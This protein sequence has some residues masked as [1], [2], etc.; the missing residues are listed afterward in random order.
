MRELM[1]PVEIGDE[2]A[3]TIA[4]GMREVSLADGEHPLELELI[5]QFE[6]DLSPGDSRVDLT[7]LDNDGLKEAF[8][9]SLALVAYAD[10]A[11]SEAEQ[12]VFYGYSTALGIDRE[13][14]HA[15][16][17]DVAEVMLSFFS[18]VEVFRDEVVEIGAHLG[19]DGEAISRALAE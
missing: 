16:L 15:L 7:T 17:I 18:G 9:K 13:R 3:H 11:L 4:A 19:L 5:K 12:T 6:A 2:A 10:G 1:Q 14:A 8:L